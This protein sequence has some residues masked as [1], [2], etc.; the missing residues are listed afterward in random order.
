MIDLYSLIVATRKTNGTT[1][2]SYYPQH[3]W[4]TIILDRHLVNQLINER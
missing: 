4:L 2:L 3:D 1:R